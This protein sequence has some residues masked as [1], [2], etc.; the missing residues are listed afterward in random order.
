MLLLVVVPLR[1]RPEVSDEDAR[2]QD[3]TRSDLREQLDAHGSIL[4]VV[5][6]ALHRYILAVG[7]LGPELALPV[8]AC[9]KL[10]GRPGLAPGGLQSLHLV[11]CHHSLENICVDLW[12]IRVVVRLLDFS[13]RRPLGVVVE[14]RN[15]LP[16][17]S[18]DGR[19][20]PRERTIWQMVS[21][22]RLDLGPAHGFSQRLSCCLP[23]KWNV[24][25]L[26]RCANAA[27]IHLVL[28][29]LKEGLSQ[30]LRR[31]VL[32]EVVDGPAQEFRS[33]QIAAHDTF[34]E[35]VVVEDDASLLD[36][37]WALG[38]LGEVP[39]VQPWPR[40]LGFL[41]QQ[42][43]GSAGLCQMIEGF[44]LLLQLGHL[45]LELEHVPTSR[46]ASL[47]EANL[48][49]PRFDHLGLCSVGPWRR[50]PPAGL[51]CQ[52]GMVVAARHFERCGRAQ[53][54]FRTLICSPAVWREHSIRCFCGILGQRHRI[55]RLVQG[56]P[57]LVQ[58][59]ASA[60]AVVLG[61]LLLLGRQLLLQ[62][63]DVRVIVSRI[64]ANSQLPS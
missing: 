54:C 22:P 12:V 5:L 8:Q 31:C 29:W 19:T 24:L 45:L 21:S 3:R 48:P 26:R 49:R 39:H 36:N 51:N 37:V 32:P 1:A 43:H 42:L 34:V 17:V 52:R 14:G 16:R 57:Q 18:G 53:M 9:L 62:L 63:S 23:F 25:D 38:V 44:A 30:F 56:A 40:L 15:V 55:R 58:S 41:V 60:E 59:P 35:G 2:P 61:L 46:G 7:A 33:V 10:L 50:C 13:H 47:A 6:G 27:K 20:T 28:S 64:N 4:D 11:V